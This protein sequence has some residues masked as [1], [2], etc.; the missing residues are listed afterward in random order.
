MTD[1]L[2]M[3][4]ALRG[5]VS[6]N[7]AGHAASHQS[8]ACH[9]LIDHP[10]LLR[11]HSVL[12]SQWSGVTIGLCLSTSYLTGVAADIWKPIATSSWLVPGSSMTA[13]GAKR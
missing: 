12:E 8:L 2:V 10:V 7:T 9:E 3:K 1:H 5:E 4:H 11:C 6:I 13:P